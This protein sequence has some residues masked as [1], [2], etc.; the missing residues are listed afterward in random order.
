MKTDAGSP[1]CSCFPAAAWHP[2]GAWEGAWNG[3]DERRRK[4]GRVYRDGFIQSRVQTRWTT[5]FAFLL[6]ARTPSSCEKHGRRGGEDR[7]DIYFPILFGRGTSIIEEFP[8]V[9]LYIQLC[10]YFILVL[11]FRGIIVEILGIEDCKDCEEIKSLWRILAK[12]IR[13]T[14]KSYRTWLCDDFNG[15]IIVQKIWSWNAGRE[16]IE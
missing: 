3:G 12:Y 7:R 4:D 1:R 15:K 6:R 8:G 14:I 13:L 11:L 10:A 5:S 16:Y 9:I 2:G